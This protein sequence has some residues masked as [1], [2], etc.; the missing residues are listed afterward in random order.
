MLTYVLLAAAAVVAL[1]ATYELRGR[2]INRRVVKTIAPHVRLMRQMADQVVSYRPPRGD[3]PIPA[4]TRPI[5]DAVENE[6]RGVGLM[7]LGDLMEIHPNGAPFAPAR[8]FIDETRTMCGWFGAIRNRQKGVYNPVM[9]VFSEA[10]SGDFFMTA[11]GASKTSVTQP[12]T[13]HRT[14]CDWNDGLATVLGR[15]RAMLL[16]TGA[17]AIEQAATLD[18]GPA[19]V[20]RLREDTSRWRASQPRGPLLEQD[21]QSLLGETYSVIG[22]QVIRSVAA[23]ET[24]S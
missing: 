15:H 23:L 4:D 7:V 13:H 5:F 21:V 11:R 6:A 22:K 18:A 2:F 1:F 8:W 3:E 12:P 20:R 19:L 24:A 14:F 17:T 16:S 9:I 10:T